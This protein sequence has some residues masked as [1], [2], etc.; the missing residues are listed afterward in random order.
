MVVRQMKE[1]LLL[2]RGNNMNIFE[3][4]SQGYSQLQSWF[5]KMFTGNI[6]LDIINGLLSGVFAIVEQFLN[7]IG[8]QFSLPADIY[9]GLNDITLGIGYIIP[10]SKFTPLLIFALAFY[11][12]R[13]IMSVYN[14]VAHT[15]I[16][17]TTIIK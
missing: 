12:G 7:L 9:D 17:K 11:V 3:I 15:S 13:I 4:W 2:L 16:R 1:M 5:D 8:L 10:M 6:F 14:R